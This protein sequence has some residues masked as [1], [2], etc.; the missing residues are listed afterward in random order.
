MFI[1]DSCLWGNLLLGAMHGD[2]LLWSNAV[3]AT[4]AA[5]CVIRTWS[6]A[7]HAIP[8]DRGAWRFALG[9]AAA[10]WLA[11]GWQRH[12]KSTR[13]DGLRS[14]HRAW[15][16]S[17]RR[18][19]LI[20]ALLL[21][22]L[23]LQPL[24]HTVGLCPQALSEGPL[25]PA[26]LVLAGLLTAMYA[27]LPG[28]R[29]A[30]YALRRMPRL[31]L[32]WIGLVW[33][34]VTA[35]WPATIANC[36][37]TLNTGNLM[38]L[39]AE[40]GCTIMALTLPFDLRDRHWDPPEFRTWPQRCGTRGTRILAAFLLLLAAGA[41]WHLQGPAPRYL[42][43]TALMW[44]AVLAAHEHRSPGYFVMLDALLVADAAV[45][46]IWPC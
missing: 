34:L 45:I 31:K 32:L 23:A 40:R 10:T 9:M 36:P 26:V 5:A 27:G 41:T 13:P 6:L 33:G 17:H 8:L 15:L 21:L 46:L 12:V 18:S 16:H 2:R 28:D 43:G 24:S 19:L 29:G 14:G 38:W 42:I 25:L 30:R 35:A 4:G 1:T 11:Y 37:G 39:I 3:I 20:V 7:G 22:P 44:P